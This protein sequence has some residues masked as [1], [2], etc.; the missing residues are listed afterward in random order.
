[1]AR[2]P[3]LRVRCA[4]LAPLKARLR[5]GSGTPIPSPR[6]APRLAGL[7]YKR[8]AA[9]ARAPATSCR[10]MV[11]GSV[12]LPSPGFFSPFPRGTRP[13]SVAQGCS[14]LDR[15]R[16]GFRRGSSCPA[17]LRRRAQAAA[18]GSRTGLSPSAAGLP[19]PFRS[20]AG[21]SLPGL[22]PARPFN[23]ALVRFGLLPLRSPLLGES[24]LISFPPLLR[25]FTSRRVAPRPYAFRAGCAPLQ[26]RGLPHSAV[27]ASSRICAPRRGFSQLVA[28]FFAPSLLPG[29]RHGPAL[30]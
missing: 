25:W 19:M 5:S 7:F 16:P 15:G 30:A 28:A 20:P 1:M 11:S 29:I 17:L 13:L 4:R 27:R 9:R 14:A 23:P 24:L 22:P 26:A 18:R 10:S 21:F 8:H 12:S 3:W 6:R 2:S